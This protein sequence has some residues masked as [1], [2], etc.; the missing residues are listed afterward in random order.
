MNLQLL[1]VNHRTAPVE[2]RERL[3][4]PERKLPDALQKV[5]TIPGVNEAMILSTCNRVE[6]IAHTANGSTELRDFLKQKLIPL[7]T[8]PIST[9]FARTMRCGTSSEWLPAWIRWL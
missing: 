7:L 6:I 4:I 2:I 1:G 5:M 9:S 8:S 3:A